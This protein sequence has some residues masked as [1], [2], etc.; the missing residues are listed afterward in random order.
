MK[1]LKMN[2]MMNTNGGKIKIRWNKDSVTF[3]IPSPSPTLTN[4]DKGSTLSWGTPLGSLEIHADAPPKDHKCPTK[5]EI[6]DNAKKYG[7]SHGY[8]DGHG[9]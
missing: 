2:E 8:Y 9:Y 5:K 3:G 7:S 4:D 1:E 6:D